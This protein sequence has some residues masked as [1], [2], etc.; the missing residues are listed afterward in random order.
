[1]RDY[2]IGFAGLTHLGL[3]SAVSCA[4]RGFKTIGYHDDPNLVEKLNNGLPNILEP[5]LSE[6]MAESKDRLNFSSD[7]SCLH[8]CDLVYIAVDV[9]TNDT[10]E[11]NL[12]SV[13]NIISKTCAAM[14]E[15]AILVI[16]CQVHPGFT[17][18]LN[19]PKERLYYQVE[20]LIFG[21]AM[22]R[23]INPERYI[24]G[25][26]DPEKVL[27]PVMADLLGAFNCPILLMKYESAELAKISINMFL[28]ASVST[29]N[30]LA[31]LCEKIGAD[32]FEI[33]PALR[34]DKRIGKYAYLTPGLGI[35]GG[36]LERD[37]KTILNFSEKF[38][39]E[40]GVV[41]AW[42]ENSQYRKKWALHKL[43]QLV[44]SVNKKPLIGLL[45]L[46]Y[47]ENTHSIKNSPS[48][49]L[50]MNLKNCIVRAFD[51]SLPQNLPD[52]G[53]KLVDSKEEVLDKADVLIIMTPWEQFRELSIDEIV[54]RMTG[55][56]IID[57]FR[58]LNG[59][60]LMIKGFTY[61]SLG[62]GEIKKD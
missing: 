2:I 23:A 36:N 24:I 35:S 48:I 50:L 37:L 25:C 45:G 38:G 12:S 4:Y 40:A 28:V 13:E 6:L 39:T 42:I 1:M 58:L 8:D 19:W 34:L 52:L 62:Q 59:R 27:L 7:I 54:N 46:T 60:E 49:E 57:P 47:K 43:Q 3:N 17:R 51:P 41:S 9:P 15:N 16:L 56:I 61:A 18:K 5:Q 53:I 14:N 55:R 31:E 29:S 10:G 11:S 32:W 44:L 26:N 20:T 30:T 21:L 33:V 22:D